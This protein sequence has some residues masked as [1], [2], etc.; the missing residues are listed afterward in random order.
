MLSHLQLKMYVVVKEESIKT[1][2]YNKKDT[3]I[4]T[5]IHTIVIPKLHTSD[6]IS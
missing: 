4:S 1:K 5:F 6:L 3:Q 2:L